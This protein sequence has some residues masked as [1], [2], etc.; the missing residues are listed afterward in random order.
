MINVPDPAKPAEL[1]F[2]GNRFVG[3]TRYF[4]ALPPW[5]LY[6]SRYLSR[7]GKMRIK[8]REARKTSNEC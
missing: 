5:P 4:A 8:V 7:I 2:G 3:R 1:F 6:T